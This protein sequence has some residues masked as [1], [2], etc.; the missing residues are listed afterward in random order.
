MVIALQ[1]ADKHGSLQDGRMVQLQSRYTAASQQ[2]SGGTDILQNPEADDD[3]AQALAASLAGANTKAA[4]SSG[5][6]DELALSS[7]HTV[8]LH[9]IYS[10]SICT[11]TVSS[12]SMQT[13]KIM[14]G[15]NATA[16]CPLD[17]TCTGLAW[18]LN[19][20]RDISVSAVEKF[21]LHRH[22]GLSCRPGVGSGLQK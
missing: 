16:R 1:L 10:L 9:S 5:A 11:R 13:S 8:W 2:A 7:S 6:N 21:M 12:A 22:P 14:T 19:A 20:S 18:L 4:T 17:A 3:L 15:S